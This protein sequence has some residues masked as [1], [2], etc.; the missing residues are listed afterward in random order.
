[1]FTLTAAI[2]HNTG[3]YRGYSQLNEVR[4]DSKRQTVWKGRN[5][6]VSIC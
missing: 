3:G 1:M 5:K 6:I 2:Q 4:K